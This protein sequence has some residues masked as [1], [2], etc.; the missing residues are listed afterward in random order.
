MP[1]KNFHIIGTRFLH[2]IG[3]VAIA[4]AVAA[5]PSSTDSTTTPGTEAVSG[6]TTATLAPPNLAAI[7]AA[8]Q[9]PSEPAELGIPAPQL[10]L[11]KFIKGTSVSLEEGRGSKVYVVEFWATWCPPCRDSIPH[12]TK[13][14]AKFKDKDVVVIGISDEDEGTVKPFVDR[15]DEKMEYSVA[16]DA[17]QRTT[18]GYMAPFMVRGIPHAFIVDKEGRI[19]WHGHPMGDLD[20][21][22]EEVL[23]GAYDIEKANRAAK[24]E[25]LVREYFFAAD[26]EGT[27]TARKI[28]D[29]V[30]RDA[31]D[32][33]MLLNEFAWRIAT[34]SAKDR[35]LELA[36]K[37]AKQALEVTKS[38]SA[39]ALDT[40]ARVL[41][42]KGQLEEA[43][44][45]QKMA[46]EKNPDAHLKPEIEGALDRYQKA[47]QNRKQ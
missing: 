22:V 2:W 3:V 36:E 45:Y 47:L 11:S 7:R 27:A 46:V 15:Q 37:A 10:Q 8:R 1:R 30:L 19:A 31:P 39:S 25:G 34:S 12:L 29:Q 33:S 13:L 23:A 18:M 17:N 16:L 6:A 44:K 20:K 40:Y 9:G 42:E 41:F 21:T 32:S 38:E 4:Q 14:Q 28:G 5:Q 26:S 35:D 24:A 43:I